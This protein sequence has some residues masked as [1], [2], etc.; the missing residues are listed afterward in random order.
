[1]GVPKPL[2]FDGAVSVINVRGGSRVMPVVHD[3]MARSFK[4]SGTA[5][6]SQPVVS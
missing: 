4:K 1:M 2:D 6:S 5:A 3:R